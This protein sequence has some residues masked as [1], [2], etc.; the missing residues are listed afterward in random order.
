LRAATLAIVTLFAGGIF[1]ALVAPPILAG[2]PIDPA[3]SAALQASAASTA[4]TTQESVASIPGFADWLVSLVPVNPVRAAADGAMLPLI[5]FALAFGLAVAGLQGEPR[6]A[7]VRVFEAIRDASMVLVQWILWTAPLGVFALAL[8]L[9]ARLGVSAF[10]ALAGYIALV[11]VMTVVFGVGVLYPMAAVVGRVPVRE[12]ARAVLPAQ[13][14]AF[15]SRSSM[16]SLPAMIEAARERLRL[17]EA[18]PAFFVPLAASVYRIGAA[19]GQTVGVLFIARLYGV[20]LGAAGLA[21]VVLTVVATSFSVPG[22]PGGSIVIMAPV[23]QSA[24]VPIEGIG[25]LLGVDT[26]PDMFRTTANV[27]GHLAISTAA[28]GRARRGG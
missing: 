9:A 4:G 22:I 8:P 1:A 23:L 10:G 27:T 17:P 14:V 5:V 25:I 12:F 6:G 19:V 24:G 28:V 20:E 15:S 2:L 26:I 11:A 18:G 13:V 3:A 16:A 21:T 7:V